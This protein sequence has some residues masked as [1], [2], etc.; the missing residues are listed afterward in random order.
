MISLKEVLRISKLARIQLTE[1]ELEKYQKELSSILDFVA[2]LKKVNLENIQPTSHP[3]AI[4]N[5]WRKD[6]V[7]ERDLE[8][9]K[10]L[11]EEA[12]LKEQDFIKVKAVF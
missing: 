1:K 8:L 7:K 10:R 6:D 2:E 11:I 3:L 12:P 5:I 4:E 9:R